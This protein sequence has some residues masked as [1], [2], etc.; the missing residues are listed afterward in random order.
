MLEYQTIYLQVEKSCNMFILPR[1]GQYEVGLCCWSLFQASFR[2]TS[3]SLGTRSCFSWDVQWW[4]C[5]DAS[6]SS[7]VCFGF[8]EAILAVG[9]WV[10]SSNSIGL[11]IRLNSIG[12]KHEWE[13]LVRALSAG[14]LA[15]NIQVREKN[16]PGESLDFLVDLVPVGE[17]DLTFSEVLVCSS[18]GKAGGLRRCSSVVEVCRGEPIPVLWWGFYVPSIQNKA[19]PLPLPCPL[20]SSMKW[21]LG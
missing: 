7:L 3:A 12:L 5:F 20:Y 6:A 4:L 17:G 19:C 9:K 21:I 18:E 1:V 16:Y 11:T 2:N 8:L 13:L 10:Y 15:D 14:R